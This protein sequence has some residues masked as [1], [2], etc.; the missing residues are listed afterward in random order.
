MSVSVSVETICAYCTKSVLEPRFC[1]NGMF[2]ETEISK[3]R[4]GLRPF[5]DLVRFSFSV[6]LPELC[7]RTQQYLCSEASLP[8]TSNRIPNEPS[9]VFQLGPFCW[10]PGRRSPLEPGRLL[11]KFFYWVSIKDE[12]EWGLSATCESST[13]LRHSGVFPDFPSV[14][15]TELRRA[16]PQWNRESRMK[17]FLRV[18]VAR[19]SVCSLLFG[20]CGFSLDEWKLLTHPGNNQG[21]SS[22]SSLTYCPF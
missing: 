18:H 7:D 11:F 2:V 4:I 6:T 3:V 16:A 9:W 14:G 10:I 1:L 21:S 17:S 19:R 5:L 8:L 20:C 13:L 15:T 22:S 12:A